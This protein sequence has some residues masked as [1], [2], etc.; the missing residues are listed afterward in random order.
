MIMILDTY[1][2]LQFSLFPFFC[3]ALLMKRRAT[4]SQGPFASRV[5]L[6]CEVHAKTCLGLAGDLIK[7]HRLVMGFWRKTSRSSSHSS[8]QSGKSYQKPRL[9]SGSA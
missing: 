2:L 9:S 8:N 4:Y 3:L 6:A 5:P 7:P 1:S